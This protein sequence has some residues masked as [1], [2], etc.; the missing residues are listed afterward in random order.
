MDN[1][2]MAGAPVQDK[3]QVKTY[4]TIVAFLAALIVLTVGAA[5]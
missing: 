3:P 1:M 4:V 5:F 2:Q